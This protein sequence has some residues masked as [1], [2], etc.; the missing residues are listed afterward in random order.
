MR[1]TSRHI[2]GL[3]AKSLTRH[4]TCWRPDEAPAYRGLVVEE[5]T[6]TTHVKRILRQLRLHDRVHD[7]I[8]AYESDL[9]QPGAQAGA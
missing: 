2:R 9:A 4:A 7:V 8:F 3:G 6:V 5:S 1:A